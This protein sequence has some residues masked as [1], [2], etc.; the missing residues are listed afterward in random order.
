M[1]GR[2]KSPDKQRHGKNT[3]RE[4]NEKKPGLD[5]RRRRFSKKPNKKHQND[6]FVFK[7][8]KR[9]RLIITLIHD[10]YFTSE[11]EP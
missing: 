8:F 7:L 11:P 1:P 10:I 6:I 9:Q 5:N 2:K 3:Q 4:F